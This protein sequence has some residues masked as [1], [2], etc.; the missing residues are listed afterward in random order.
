MSVVLRPQAFQKT[1][2]KLLYNPMGTIISEKLCVVAYTYIKCNF[3]SDTGFYPLLRQVI[4]DLV[5]SYF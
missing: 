1:H 5:S 2:E 4:N 3:C